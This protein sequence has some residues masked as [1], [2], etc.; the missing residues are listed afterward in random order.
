[1]AFF[2]LGAAG[3]WDACTLTGK[4][5]QRPDSRPLAVT[6]RQHPPEYLGGWAFDPDSPLSADGRH[7]FREALA[8]LSGPDD[9]AIARSGEAGVP[10][11][12]FDGYAAPGQ[13]V[14]EAQLHDLMTASREYSPASLE[15]VR[16]WRLDL[17]LVDWTLQGEPDVWEAMFDYG[18]GD[19]NGIAREGAAVF[20]PALRGGEDWRRRQAGLSALRGL[21]LALNMDPSW[22]ACPA[23]SF[24]WDDASACGGSRCGAACPPGA[25]GCR[26]EA[27]SCMAECRDGSILSLTDVDHSTLRFNPAPAAGSAHSEIDWYRSAPEAWAKPGRFGIAP[28][29]G[30]MPPFHP[31]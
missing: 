6:V 2:A 26:Y 20:W 1:M 30:P 8:E 24:C 19:A 31:Q 10:Y 13:P 5:F 16:D 22:G 4:L 15:D 23:A 25:Q 18:D 3:P 14:T 28:V 29:S 7:S 27:Y 9:L 12:P 11:L 17:F 21:G